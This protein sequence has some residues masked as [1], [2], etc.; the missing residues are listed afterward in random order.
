MATPDDMMKLGTTLVRLCNEGKE[1]ELQKKYYA[2]DAVS[3]EAVD[4]AGHGPESRGLDAIKAKGEWWY[5][6][7]EV[8][9]ASAEGPFVHGGDRFS[10]IFQMD[11]TR[12]DSGERIQMKEVGVYQV[13]DGKI[14]REE[15]Y[16]PVG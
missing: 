14:V 13:R 4:F 1:A 5:G 6:A 8:H 3:A 11:V 12:K 16:Y 9:S 2:P 7:H 15:F 10:V